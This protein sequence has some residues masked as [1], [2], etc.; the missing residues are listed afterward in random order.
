MQR[1]AT[2]QH[3]Q[4]KAAYVARVDLFAVDDSY[5]G[6]EGLGTNGHPARKSPRRAGASR[7]T[8]TP[9]EAL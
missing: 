2:V 3:I 9:F 8:E 7:A 6:R 1:S 4:L 5:S